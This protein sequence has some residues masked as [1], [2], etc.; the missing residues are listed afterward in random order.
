LPLDQ[1]ETDT[2]RVAGSKLATNDPPVPTGTVPDASSPIQAASV[3]PNDEGALHPITELGLATGWTEK[4]T[5]AGLDTVGKLEWA[6]ANGKLTPGEVKGVGTRAIN[7]IHEQLTIFRGKFPVP[8]P[9]SQ[10][11]SQPAQNSMPTT[12]NSGTESSP[13]SA[14]QPDSS[15]PESPTSQEGESNTAPTAEPSLTERAA[16]REQLADDQEWKAALV[17]C[18]RLI[19]KAHLLLNKIGDGPGGPQVAEWHKELT[20]LRAWVEDSEDIGVKM[21][22]RIRS[23]DKGLAELEAKT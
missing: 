12:E 20:E 15:T 1:A 14:S 11:S 3:T 9:S 6:M 4:L 2:L 13:D 22:N 10:S 17:D 19:P 23:I 5:E 18:D 16:A 21:L 8:D 7:A